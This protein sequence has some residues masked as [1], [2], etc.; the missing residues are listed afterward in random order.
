MRPNVL[1]RYDKL[2][3]SS[4]ENYDASHD[5][6][7]VRTWGRVQGGHCLRKRKRGISWKVS[8]EILPDMGCQVSKV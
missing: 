4:S 8:L 5:K 3:R 1:S 6:F 2:P 7:G